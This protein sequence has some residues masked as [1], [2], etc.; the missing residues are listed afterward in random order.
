[1]ADGKYR[2]ITRSDFDGLV[3]G[4]LLKELDLIDDVLFAHPKDMQDGKVPVTDRDI[5]CNLPHV[6]GAALTFDH[7]SSELERKG[8]QDAVVIDPDA[9]S[10]ARVVWRH[11][12]GADRFDETLD[13]MMFAVDRAASAD[14]TLDEV[15]DAESWTLLSFMMDSRTG[16]GRF[17]DFR[18]SNYQ[19]MMKL[20]E[21]LRTG[22]I[23]PIMADP[24]VQERV[25]MYQSQQTQFKQQLERVGRIEGNVVVLDLR[26]EEQIFAGNRFLIYAMYPSSLISM[27]VMWGRDKQNVVLACGKSIFDRTSTVNIGSLMLRHGGGGHS[28]A[29]T[30]QI[31]PET[32]DA[33]IAELLPDMQAC[34]DDDGQA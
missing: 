21:M 24:D 14:W 11:Y 19:L 16:L 12:G 23:D 7:H 3:C 17:R 30:C 20:M 26:E 10:A 28:A 1:M 33:V 4:A 25:A 15:L 2:L 13:D 5:I 27:H 32:V 9:P 8:E 29:G 34:E 22:Q 18:I 31:A 6:P